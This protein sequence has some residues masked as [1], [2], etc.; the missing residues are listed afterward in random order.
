VNVPTNYTT[1]VFKALGGPDAL[2]A[3]MVT[4]LPEGTVENNAVSQRMGEKRANR[5]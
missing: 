1:C 2:S 4:D 5:Q 3:S